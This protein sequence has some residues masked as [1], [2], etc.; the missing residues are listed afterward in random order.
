MDEDLIRDLENQRFQAIL[1]K[2][3]LTFRNLCHSSLHYMHSNGIADN[4][5][6]YIQKCETN[7]YQYQW[8]KHPIDKIEFFNNCAFVFGE[9]QA[10]LLINSIPK[11]LDNKTLTI[12]IKEQTS[13]KFYAFQPTS[14][15]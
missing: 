3:Y 4:L 6:S 13:W 11:Q 9:M 15:A 2:D 10:E 12:W 1:N 14:K 7:F 8:I 5:D